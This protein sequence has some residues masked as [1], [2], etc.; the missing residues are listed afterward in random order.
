M[1]SINQR[2]LDVPY[3]N[4]LLERATGILTIPWQN[5]FRSLFE[6]VLPLGL[7]TSFPLVNNQA[8]AANI[9]G[10]QFDYVKTNQVIIEY[11]IQRITGSISPTELIQ[12][13]VFA[14]AYKPAAQTW[15]IVTIGSTGP[16]SAGIT[17]SVTTGGQV[18]YT[19][20]NMTGSANISKITYRA[21][22][23]AAKVG[24]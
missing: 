15:H 19:S 14:L 4:T 13:G 6:R 10:L 18:Q 8:S 24:T 11:I 23:L 7:E 3:Q 1:A 5:F 9:E 22:T 17:F 21:R 16:D 20:T 12:T 2:S